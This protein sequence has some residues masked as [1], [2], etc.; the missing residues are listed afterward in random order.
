MG[1]AASEEGV[2]DGCPDCCIVIAAEEVV[3]ATYSE[4]EDCILDSVVVYVISAVKHL[5]AQTWKKSI[6]IDLSSSH[7]GFGCEAFRG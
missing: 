2:Y 1:L 7:S 5:A 3:L 4:R 6:G